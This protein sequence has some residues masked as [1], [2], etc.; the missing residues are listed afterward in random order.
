[1]KVSTEFPIVMV[2]EKGQRIKQSNPNANICPC[3]WCKTIYAFFE[4]PVIENHTFPDI[5]IHFANVSL[6]LNVASLKCVLL[7]T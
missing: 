3:E 7:Q 5:E 4:R 2:D 1:M 6:V